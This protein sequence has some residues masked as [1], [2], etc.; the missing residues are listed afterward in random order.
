[1]KKRMKQAAALMLVLAMTLA[2]C[3]ESEAVVPVVQMRMLTQA[4]AAAAYAILQNP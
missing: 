1:M 3:G 4:G 2:G